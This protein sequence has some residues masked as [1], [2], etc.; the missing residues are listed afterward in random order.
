MPPAVV[1]RPLP[2]EP[3]PKVVV[4]SLPPETRIDETLAS[5]GAAALALPSAPDVVGCLQMLAADVAVTQHRSD[6]PSDLG[7]FFSTL[8]TDEAGEAVAALL[9][10]QRAGAE[11]GGGDSRG[12]TVRPRRRSPRTA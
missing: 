6:V 12:D 10:N 9:F 8:L 7:D 5:P 3:A 1:G 2:L 11:F 4:A